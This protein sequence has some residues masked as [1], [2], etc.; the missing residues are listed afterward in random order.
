MIFMVWYFQFAT[1]IK[2]EIKSMVNNKKGVFA[3]L[4]VFSEYNSGLERFPNCDAY[5]DR[6]LL[7]WKGLN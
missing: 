7:I 6:L 5:F 3:V 2:F 1:R 4:D